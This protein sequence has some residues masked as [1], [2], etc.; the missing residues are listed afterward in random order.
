MKKKSGEQRG[1]KSDLERGSE[2][3]HRVDG[4]LKVQEKLGAGPPAVVRA[5]VVLYS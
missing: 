1:I 4:A 2:T 3:D 5:W